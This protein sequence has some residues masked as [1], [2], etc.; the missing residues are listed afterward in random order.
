MINRNGYSSVWSVSSSY[1]QLKG[2]PGHS[3]MILIA[4]LELNCNVRLAGAKGMLALKRS[5]ASGIAPVADEREGARRGEGL[6]G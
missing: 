3:L 6:G 1:E 2:T 4:L 5:V